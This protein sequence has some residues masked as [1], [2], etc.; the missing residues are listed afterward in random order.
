MQNADEMKE[1]LRRTAVLAKLDVPK[2]PEEVQLER[3]LGE[4]LRFVDKMKEFPLAEE[5]GETEGFSLAEECSE[6]ENGAGWKVCGKR[7]GFLER[8][9]EAAPSAIRWR[10]D[11]VTNRN[12]RE[13]MMSNAPEAC[14]QGFVAPK[15]F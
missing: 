13:A 8:E 6:T 5:C 9:A 11:E 15:S 7:E 12:A 3:D 1:T 4:I 14:A 10:K 2:G